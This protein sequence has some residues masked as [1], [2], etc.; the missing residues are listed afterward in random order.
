MGG[1][2]FAPPKIRKDTIMIEYQPIQKEIEIEGFNSL[3]Y[4]EFGK[5]FSH[6]PEKHN[7]WEMVYVDSGSIIAI[8]DGIGIKLEQGQLIFHEPNEIHAHVSD[9]ESSNNMLVV[10][11]TC[12]NPAM[13]FF[14]RKT[15]NADKSIKTLLSLFIDEAKMALTT[16]P[17]DYNNKQCPDFSNAKFGSHQMLSCYFTEL[18]IKL[19]RSGEAGNK[20]LLQSEKSRNIA[21][22]S[23][24]ELIIDYL[25]ENVYSSISLVDVC[26]HFI[27][28]KT[29]LCNTFKENNGE[30]I[31]SFYVSLKLNEAKR[32]LR[33]EAI[34]VTE[35][36]EQLG[37]SCIHSFSRAFKK[38]F[39]YTPL[40]YK[41]KVAQ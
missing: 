36:S 11:F 40:E 3:Y 6:T 22:N 10:S 37:Y 2:G 12:N 20:K 4:F 33:E 23:L 32:L 5:N 19:I 15:F 29:L 34:S 26:N 28:G 21:Q 18:L 38:K 35:I 1:E 8:T 41:N 14:K 31:M 7:F 39:G 24:N 27:M 16:I 17:G 25:K 13:Q 9:K 30:S